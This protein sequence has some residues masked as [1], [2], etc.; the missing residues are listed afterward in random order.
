MSPQAKRRERYAPGNKEE[1]V[2]PQ[3]T[4][5]DLK[6][7]QPSFAALSTGGKT[8]E[9]RWNDR[10]YQVGDYLMLREW[11]GAAGYSGAH[12]LV[13]VTH[14]LDTDAAPFNGPGGCALRRGWVMLSLEFV[15]LGWQ[16]PGP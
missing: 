8:A 5:H 9:L 7:Q 10:G 1:P 3:P 11:S 16:A 2:N 6:C 4:I 12:L 15:P 14:I 13:A